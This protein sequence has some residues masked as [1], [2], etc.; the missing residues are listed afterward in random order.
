[1]ADA[2]RDSLNRPIALERILR[3]GKSEF[4]KG[5]PDSYIKNSKKLKADV[6]EWQQ[7][8]LYSIVRRVLQGKS[9]IAQGSVHD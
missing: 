5:V 2:F 6:F 3:A 4:L 9:I 8:A 7:P 1:M